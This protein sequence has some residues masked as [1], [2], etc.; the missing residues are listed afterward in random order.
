VKIYL[1]S[2]V[3]FCAL[4][5][6]SGATIDGVSRDYAVSGFL[7]VDDISP[8]SQRAECVMLNKGPYITDALRILDH[9]LKRM[10]YST[11]IELLND[12]RQM[13][14]LFYAAFYLTDEHY[15]DKVKNMKPHDVVKALSALAQ[16]SRLAVFR[17]LVKRG[18]EGFTPSVIADKLGIAAPTLS[19]HLK[20]LQNAGLIVV[21]REGRF[22]F[23]STRFDRMK[24]LVG[25]L[26]DECCSHADEACD[27]DCKPVVA[28]VRRRSA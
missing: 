23:Y 13:L 19:F 20:E 24:G 6:Q 14:Q 10:D 18:P 12:T 22:L 3:D 17:L 1:V 2:V 8:M 11:I 9:I 7:T 21:R 27:G 25:F 5:L 16:E 4:A 15:F 28:Q 26:T